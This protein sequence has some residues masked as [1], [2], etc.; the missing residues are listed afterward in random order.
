[1]SDARNPNLVTKDGIHV[2][3]GQVWRDCDKRSNGRTRRV[4]A[5]DELNGRVQFGGPTKSWTAIRR[6][7]RH[8][9]GW[10]LVP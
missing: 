7:H 5:V 10:E 2:R 4:I 8:A 6:M 1:M 9:T 3:I